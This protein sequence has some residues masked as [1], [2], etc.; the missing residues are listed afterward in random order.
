[1]KWHFTLLDNYPFTVNN[2]PG[3]YFLDYEEEVQP[4]IEKLNKEGFLIAQTNY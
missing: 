3:D 4:I 1:M 2:L